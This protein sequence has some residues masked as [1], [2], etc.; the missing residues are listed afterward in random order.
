MEML[1]FF[2]LVFFGLQFSFFLVYQVTCPLYLNTFI[3]G[4]SSGLE[5]KNKDVTLYSGYGFSLCFKLIHSLSCVLKGKAKIILS[6][7]LSRQTI[8][9]SGK[10]VIFLLEE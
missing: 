2:V 7:L 5:Y 6:Q 1:N 8:F 10:R 3:C 4:F 9:G